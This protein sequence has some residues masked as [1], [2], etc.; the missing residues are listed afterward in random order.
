MNSP[1]I[2]PPGPRLDAFGMDR[3]YIERWS[4]TLFHFLC[5]YYWRIETLGLENVPQHGRAI[6]VGNHR[7]FIPFDAIMTLHLVLKN[8]GRIP[9]FLVHPGLLKFRPIAKFITR[10]GGV[11]AC[12]E[13]AARI[14]DTGE[15]LGVLPE[16]V[17]GAFSLYHD[18]YKLLTFGRDD[19]VKMSLRH[20]API[21]PYVIVGSADALPIFARVESRWWKKRMLWPYLPVSIPLPLP[22]KWHIQFLPPVHIYQDHSPESSSHRSIV[23]AI[24]RDVRN[25]MQQTIDGIVSRRRSRFW[26]SV[27][28]SDNC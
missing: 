1:A 8:T 15:L 18:A 12:R 11:L 17:E 3:H 27:F 28:K 24:S 20:R 7:G 26:G 10:L 21:V 22:A 16:G 19:F 2:A 14:L 5:K 25:Q 6:L 4:N 23:N 13:N 9:R